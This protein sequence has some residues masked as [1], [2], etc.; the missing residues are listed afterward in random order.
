L[1][2]FEIFFNDSREITCGFAFY[3][4]AKVISLTKSS[5]TKLPGENSVKVDLI[6]SGTRS[7]VYT[8]IIFNP[9][10][11][12][13]ITINNANICVN[14][15]TTS[16]LALYAL[17][18]IGVYNSD[19]ECVKLTNYSLCININTKQTLHRIEAPGM[20][21]LHGDRYAILRCPEIEQHLFASHSYEKY[22]M[23]LAKFKLAVLGYD[24]SRFDFASLPS[25]EFHPIGKLSQLTFA[26]ER[27]NGGLYN[28]RGINHTIT[29]AIRY[30]VPQQRGK[31][32]KFILNPQYDPDFFRYQ[33]NEE[34]ESE[35]SDDEN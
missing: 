3:Q 13:S 29:I 34:S 30:L 19:T 23:G 33:Q 11:T 25:R 10:D 6:D 1:E 32:D 17:N 31:F 12:N 14:L 26:F 15:S 35:I 7:G 24:E 18:Y 22:S 8:L 28:F 9:R 4:D 2:S 21:N 5:F 27:P 20:Y 16:E